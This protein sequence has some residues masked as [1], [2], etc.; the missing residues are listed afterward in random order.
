MTGLIYKEFCTMKGQ[1]RSWVF[2]AFILGVYAMFFK[3]VSFLYMMTSLVG[4]MSTL[5]I[6]TYD[7]MY[8]C[9]EF[10]AA[11]PVSRKKIVLSKYLFLLI[12]DIGVTFV[13]AMIIMLLTLFLGQQESGS[14]MA[15]AMFGVLGVTIFL[16]SLLL[17]FIYRL[18]AE[19]ARILLMLLAVSPF[20]I[21]SVL[22]ERVMLPDLEWLASFAKIVPLILVVW[23]II[24]Y[25]ISVSIYRKKDL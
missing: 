6:F 13:A 21:V 11:M 1:L 9:D 5:T 14:E 4:I 19:K 16:Q 10:I 7:K 3:S 2:A 25:Y 24:S 15:I 20:L 23:A 18:G 12:L 8:R 17:P 22:K